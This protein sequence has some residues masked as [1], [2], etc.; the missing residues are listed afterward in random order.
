MLYI[1]YVAY[2]FHDSICNKA[3]FHIYNIKTHFHYYIMA[4]HSN[5]IQVAV[6]AKSSPG[7]FSCGLFLNFV[8]CIHVL[9]WSLHFPGQL[10][11]WL[12]YCITNYEF[13]YGL[14]CVICRAQL[15]PFGCA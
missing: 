4:V 12:S 10:E 2:I 9:R 1:S 14:L 5:F 3:S 8:G 13:G 15:M 11:S 7:C 6:G